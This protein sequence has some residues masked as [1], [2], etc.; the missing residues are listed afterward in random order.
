M[1][2]EFLRLTNKEKLTSQAANG[3]ES[4]QIDQW[5]GQQGWLLINF[6]TIVISNRYEYLLETLFIKLVSLNS[7]YP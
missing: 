2:K 5:G 1:I 4:P 6:L 3:K 7:K